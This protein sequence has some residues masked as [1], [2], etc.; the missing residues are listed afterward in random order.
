MLPLVQQNQDEE[1]EEEEE[2]VSRVRVTSRRSPHK[3]ERVSGLVTRSQVDIPTVSK[4]KQLRLIKA[5]FNDA[6]VLTV[7]VYWEGTAHHERRTT[8]G[9]FCEWWDVKAKSSSSP[10]RKMLLDVSNSM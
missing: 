7:T 4:T 5:D 8:F 10:R 2:G 1:E 6:D 9:T 3:V